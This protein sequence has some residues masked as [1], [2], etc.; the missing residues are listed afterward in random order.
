MSHPLAVACIFVMLLLCCCDAG[1]WGKTGYHSGVGFNSCEMYM[2]GPPYGPVCPWLSMGGLI[3]TSEWA[4]G[5]GVR[6]MEGGM[7]GRRWGGT[8]HCWSGLSGRL[9]M[10]LAGKWRICSHGETGGGVKSWVTGHFGR[11]YWGEKGAQM[12]LV[13]MPG[14]PLGCSDMELRQGGR[15][16]RGVVRLYLQK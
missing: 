15:N 10:P 9:Q 5:G 8:V 12:G 1:G 14:S 13:A 3:F 16:Q 11:V 6:L 2:D 7:L 4:E